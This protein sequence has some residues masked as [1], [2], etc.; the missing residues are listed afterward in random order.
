MRGRSSQLRRLG[1]RFRSAG[2]ALLFFAGISTVLLAIGPSS[3]AWSARQQQGQQ[4][5]AAQTGESSSQ[6]NSTF[7]PLPA[8]KDV[9]VGTFYMHK[10]DVDAAIARFQDAIRLQPKFAKARLLLAAA[11]EK[12]GDREAAVKC[13]QEY[14]QAFP[15][16]PDAKKI[17]KK[18]Q[19]LSTP[20][21]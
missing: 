3:V 16:A 14:L 15:N 13:Y 12:K 20:N 5:P 8:E 18:I 10:G 21:R 17:Q 1:D 2:T 6:E 9:E 11:Y 7:D 4:K 19:K